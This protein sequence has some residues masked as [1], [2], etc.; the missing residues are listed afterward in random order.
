MKI[1]IKL[2]NM[3]IKDNI[4][5]ILESLSIQEIEEAFNG[6]DDYILLEIYVFNTGFVANISNQ[7]YSK[8][9]EKEANE[10]GNLFADKDTMMILFNECNIEI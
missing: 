9:I 1:G 3:I 5:K 7:S 8:T 4:K 2:S 10:N 6:P